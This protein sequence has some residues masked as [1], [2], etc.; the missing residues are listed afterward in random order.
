M[1]GVLRNGAGFVASALQQRGYQFGA[2][3]VCASIAAQRAVQ[4]LVR[5]ALVWLA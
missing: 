1:L 3:A 5:S 2:G 4:F